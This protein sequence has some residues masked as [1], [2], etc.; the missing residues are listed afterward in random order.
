MTVSKS[1]VWTAGVSRGLGEA[2]GLGGSGVLGEATG[3]GGRRA[4]DE[5]TVLARASWEATGALTKTVRRRSMNGDALS[6]HSFVL[7]HKALFVLC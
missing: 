5:V 7:L 2:M 4:L 1:P 6:A 3:L